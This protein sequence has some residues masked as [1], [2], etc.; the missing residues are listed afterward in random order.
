MSLG[1][2]LLFPQSGLAALYRQR[3][4]M[5]QQYQWMENF[6]PKEPTLILDGATFLP[7]RFYLWE[8]SAQ[9]RIFQKKKSRVL[10]AERLNPSEIDSLKHLGYHACKL[11]N[12]KPFLKELP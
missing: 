11:A 1:S 6:N 3:K 4:Q 7:T 2:S 8:R 9:N 12:E 5:L 10:V